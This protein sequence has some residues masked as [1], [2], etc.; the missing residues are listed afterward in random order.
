MSMRDY[1]MR[2]CAGLLLFIFF[3]IILRWFT[4][5]VLIDS[6]KWDNELTRLVLWDNWRLPELI[7]PREKNIAWASL[8]PFQEPEPEKNLLAELR[9]QENNLRV[10]QSRF[11]RWSQTFLPG[12]TSI[13]ETGRR[14]DKLIGWDIRP[15]APEGVQILSDGW[16]FYPSLPFDIHEQLA[17][18][19]S[20]AAFCQEQGAKFLFVPNA[21][22][23]DTKTDGHLIG[24]LD[25]CLQK[26]DT[27]VQGLQERGVATLDLYPRM[28]EDFPDTPYH[29][30][31]FRTDHHWLP[32]TGL[33]AALQIGR[34]LQTE[35][36]VPLIDTPLRLENYQQ[37][38]YPAYFLGS[39]GKKLTT[40]LTQPD[41]FMLLYPQFPTYL[42]YEIPGLDIDTY[43]DFS[44]TYDMH[45][46]ERKDFYGSNPYAA[47]N[48]ADCSLI[49]MENF[50]PDAANV[51]ILVVKDSFTNSVAPFLAL[52]VKRMDILDPRWFKGSIRSYVQKTKPDF[53]LVIHTVKIDYPIERESHQNGYDFR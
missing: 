3:M 32:T 10:E 47:Y 34:W 28:H 14:Y 18:T 25:F 36:G 16:L 53:V 21:P 51:K 39:Q 50:A 23:L 38:I 46:V 11:A 1:I 35:G 42:H 24:R 43:G 5:V 20:F 30:L 6:C 52:C 45:E 27:M 13:V 8:Y 12:Y 37:K 4:V 26:K 7:H 29:Q 2:F 19:A 9:Q 15:I 31:F 49:H 44:I 33:Y 41:D 22:A 17:E 40:V 48:Y